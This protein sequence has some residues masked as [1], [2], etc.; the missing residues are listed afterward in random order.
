[1][2]TYPLSWIYVKGAIDLR[3]VRMR[4][5][6]KIGVIEL[7]Q[8]LNR[9]RRFVNSLDIPQSN[10]KVFGQVSELSNLENRNVIGVFLVYLP[11]ENL[12]RHSAFPGSKKLSQHHISLLRTS[13]VDYAII[14]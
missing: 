6:Q 2:R 11:E 12:L 4:N 9:R 7:N 8:F 13:L 5:N 3:G 14:R 1:M 10:L